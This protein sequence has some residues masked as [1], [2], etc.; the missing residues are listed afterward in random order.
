MSNAD[1]GPENNGSRTQ[2]LK[3][4]EQFSAEHGVT[5]QLACDSPC[6][7][8]YNPV[9]RVCG[10]LENYWNGAPR[11]TGDH[12]RGMAAG[13]TPQNRARFICTM[14]RLRAPMG[15]KPSGQVGAG[16]SQT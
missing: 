9:E 15:S 8:K 14:L 13:A 16:N 3:R 2:W 7:R 10:V 4:L 11:L 1:K 6:H 5:V 12:A